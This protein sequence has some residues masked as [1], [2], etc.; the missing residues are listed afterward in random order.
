MT[1]GRVQVSAP[2]EATEPAGE[3]FEAFFTRSYPRALARAVLLCGNREDAEDAVLEAY[4]AAAERWADRLR[5]YESPE[6]WVSTVVEQRLWKTARARSKQ[7]EALLRV[8][9]P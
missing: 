2:A 5:G 3:E 9:V 6:G 1:N 8:P 4:A 7:R